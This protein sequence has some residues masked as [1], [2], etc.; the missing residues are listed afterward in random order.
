VSS[1][2]QPPDKNAVQSGQ[3]VMD[4]EARG[5][6]IMEIAAQKAVGGEI[7]VPLDLFFVGNDD[8]GSIGCN[9]G[10]EQ[11]AIGEFY[12]AFTALSRRLEVQ[13]IW[14]RI[15][16][17]DD[18]DQW[19]YTDT[20]YVISSLSQAE[21]VA[22][23]APLKFDEVVAGWMYGKPASAPTPQPGFTPI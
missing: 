2:P 1:P 22:A 14:V 17:V 7:A 10:P 3:R 8:L 15:Y 16:S 11:P 9:L 12:A 6:L 20:V 4:I 18:E 13:D 21:I 5:R 19:P 23:L